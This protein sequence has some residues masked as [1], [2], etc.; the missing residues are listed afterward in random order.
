MKLF[1]RKRGSVWGALRR[2][3]KVTFATSKDWN[4]CREIPASP[5]YTECSTTVILCIVKILQKQMYSL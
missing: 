5:Y 1:L 4:G 2:V 3:Y